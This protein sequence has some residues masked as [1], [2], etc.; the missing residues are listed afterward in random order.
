MSKRLSKPAASCCFKHRIKEDLVKKI[1]AI[2]LGL[3]F[4]WGCKKD[5]ASK[6]AATGGQFYYVKTTINGNLYQGS[7]VYGI[8]TS[9]VIEI[10]FSQPINT[11]SVASGVS[12]SKSEPS[13]NLS[14][15]MARICAANPDAS[16]SVVDGQTT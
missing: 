7:D 1:S 10:I 16:S 3:V 2:I 5:S 9:P 11:A 4:L 12:E 15:P 6:S 14:R 8:S 13:T